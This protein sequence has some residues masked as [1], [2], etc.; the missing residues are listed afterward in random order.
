MLI[1][2]KFQ[3]RVFHLLKFMSFISVVKPCL[4]SRLV[5]QKFSLKFT[6]PLK[7]I[8]DLGYRAVTSST[9]QFLASTRPACGRIFKSPVVAPSL[10]LQWPLPVQGQW[11]RGQQQSI[12]SLPALGHR[13]P[14]RPA[15]GH[16]WPTS[17]GPVK[18]SFTGLVM[19]CF[20]K[21]SAGV[22]LLAKCWAITGPVMAQVS[23]AD[24][25]R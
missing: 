23:C 9:Q 4:S 25:I 21:A 19:A 14:R 7:V 12:Q 2:K 8:S 10:G 24:M 3:I 6:G 17:A 11:W 22:L 5:P 13:W 20:S 15:I 1:I 16:R 18:V